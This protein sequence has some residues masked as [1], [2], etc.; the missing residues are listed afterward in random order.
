M[1]TTAPFLVHMAIEILYVV[2]GVRSKWPVPNE[3]LTFRETEQ[4]V[5]V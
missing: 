5:V 2:G 4:N 3:I 1:Y